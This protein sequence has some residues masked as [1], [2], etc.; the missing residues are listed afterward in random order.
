MNFDDLL[1]VVIGPW[2]ITCDGQYMLYQFYLLFNFEAKGEFAFTTVVGQV[3]Q[4]TFNKH[5]A[6]YAVNHPIVASIYFQPPM[7]KLW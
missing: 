7:S 2:V 6:W 1:L 3:L 4:Y 5:V